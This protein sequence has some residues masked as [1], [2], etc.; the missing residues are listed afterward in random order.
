MVNGQLVMGPNDGPK[1]AKIGVLGNGYVMLKDF[2]GDDLSPVNDAKVSYDKESS[3][4]GAKEARL[5]NFLAREDH[6][7][8]FRQSALKF[9]VYAPLM[10][11]RQW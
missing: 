2:M 11:A 5:L 3:E 7:S 8:P 10:I 4:F 9:E 6:S 1:D